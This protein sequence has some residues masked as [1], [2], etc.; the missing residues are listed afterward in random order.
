MTDDKNIKIIHL[1]RENK[2]RTY[3]SG[4]IARKT[5]QW[6]RKTNHKISIEDK[7]IKIETED[8]LEKLKEMK[9]F[10][11]QTK[12]QFSGHEFLEISYEDLVSDKNKIMGQVFELLNIKNGPLQSSHKKQNSETLKD[13][14]LNYDEVKSAL[15]DSEFEYLLK[16]NSM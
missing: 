4:Q 10:E 9:K 11:D 2:L 14:I 16:M 3:V 6:T 12:I 8:L 1:V 7:Q 5:N 15:Q 13:I